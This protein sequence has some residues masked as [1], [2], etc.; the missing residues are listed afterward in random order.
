[1]FSKIIT[2]IFAA[3][4]IS[5]AN[6]FIGS[7]LRVLEPIL[8]CYEGNAPEFAGEKTMAARVNL[9]SE[10]DELKLS[11]LGMRVRLQTKW[12][13]DKLNQYIYLGPV[14]KEGGLPNCRFSHDV[15]KIQ[16][17]ELLILLIF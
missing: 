7:K 4:C 13:P 9:D 8:K 14:D 10:V 16:T 11:C 15:T 3:N 2:V 12:M 5:A 17:T 1:M 6:G